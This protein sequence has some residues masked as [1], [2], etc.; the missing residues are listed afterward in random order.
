MT[1]LELNSAQELIFGGIPESTNTPNEFFLAQQ[2]K[3]DQLDALSPLPYE[4]LD[5]I[6][7][8]VYY[9]DTDK[10]YSLNANTKDLCRSVSLVNS[11]FY[12]LS[13]KYVFR[14]ANFTRS[15]FFDRFLRN[16]QKNNLLGSYVKFL[17]FSEFTSVGLGRTGQMMQEIQMVTH[18]TILQCLELTPNLTEFLASESI[19]G[20]I[21][22]VVVDHLFNKLPKLEAVDFCG[23]SGIG[24][25]QSFSNLHIFPNSNVKNLSFHECTDLTNEAFTSILRNLTALERL[26]LS[27]TQVTIQTLN[28]SLQESARL[29]HLSIARCSRLGAA[30]H[31]IEFLTKHPAV[32]NDSLLWLNL[33]VD[34]NIASPFNTNTLTFLLGNMNASNLRYLNLAGVDV[35]PKH[36]MLIAERFPALES[37][38]IAH[39]QLSIDDLLLVLSSLHNLKFIDLTGNKNITRWSLDNNQLLTC[40]PTLQAIEVDYK[41]VDLLDDTTGK[42][43]VYNNGALEIWKTYNDN[44]KGRRA[45]VFKLNE[46][47]L[48]KELNGQSLNFNNNLV[49]FDINTGRKIMQKI[50]RPAFLK[51]ASRKINC[52]KGLFQ[53]DELAFPGEFTERGIYKYYSLNK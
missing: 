16:L 7:G 21:D 6:I 39:S 45:W 27:H 29:T 24:F 51:Y 25:S 35:E 31:L 9:N 14:Y 15:I 53:N 49:Y 2:Q 48:K 37:L 22:G 28:D 4:L 47:Q 26:D 19:E 38:V 5:K 41:V 11:A 42:L 18:K 3:L 50:E 44:G 52:S 32:N 8:Y 40:C 13:L 20:D 23:S 1:T 33:Q 46:V 43:R 36:L 30:R 34:T 10:I 17:D 12:L